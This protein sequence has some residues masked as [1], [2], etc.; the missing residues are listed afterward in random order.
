[1]GIR[2][3]ESPRGKEIVGTANGQILV[4]NDTTKRWDVGA[5]PGSSA[6]PLGTVLFPVIDPS[7]ITV[8]V[9]RDS[10]PVTFD[11]GGQFVAG[12]ALL[13][14]GIFQLNY[15]YGAGTGA[16]QCVARLQYSIDA[17]STWLEAMQTN[18]ITQV[19][20]EVGQLAQ[21]IVRGIP[22]EGYVPFTV[23][24]TGDQVLFRFE[25]INAGDVGPPAAP[26]FNVDFGDPRLDPRITVH[27][28]STP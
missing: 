5:A 21:Q 26:P 19:T 12:R 4:W 2:I 23:A 27:L 1:M 9:V 20:D 22:L 15:N 8:G 14:S 7:N 10:D 18:W 25:V 16:F 17:G 24:P 28:V 6:P 11:C 3:K 13:V